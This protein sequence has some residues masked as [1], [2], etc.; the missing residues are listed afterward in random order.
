MERNNIEAVFSLSP[1][2]QGILF[3]ST[4][5]RAEDAYF[6]QISIDLRGCVDS[7]ALI[8]AWQCIIA[9]HPM[10]RTA[11]TSN[12]E[13]KPV[14]IVLKSAAMPWKELDWR[15]RS[16][17]EQKSAFEQFLK[18]DR[19]H[20]LDFAK[21][22]LMRL[23]LIRLSDDLS[24]LVW[25]EHH[26]ALDGWSVQLL[27]NEL[28]SLYSGF[29]RGVAPALSVARP[30]RDYVS[31][32]GKQNHDEAE[33]YWRD[34]LKGFQAVTPIGKS[35]PVGVRS[36]AESVE[37]K[38]AT[39]EGGLSSRIQA[40]GRKLRLTPNTIVQGAWAILLSRYSGED[41]LVY[42][43]TVS[44]RPAELQGVESTVG[45]FIN[46]L[47]VRVT[48]APEDSVID[49]LRRMQAQQVNTREYEYSSL[50]DVQK[51]SELDSRG[52]LFDSIFVFE[53]YPPLKRSEAGQEDITIAG[54]SAV[55]GSNYR[56][57]FVAG[58]GESLKLKMLYSRE[59]FGDEINHLIPHF[60]NV[61]ES[62]LRDPEQDVGRISL[63]AADENT[64]ILAT[65]A[66]PSPAF[67]LESLA[68]LFEEQALV[69][70]GRVAVESSEG[71]L[72]YSQLNEQADRLAGH[73]R[74]KGAGPEQVVG[75]SVDRS[76]RMIV[77]L[78]G[79]LK[80][81]AAYLSLDAN[82]PPA[83]LNY[84]IQDAQLRLV[85]TEQQYEDRFTSMVELVTVDDGRVETKTD[86]LSG[87]PAHSAPKAGNLAY[88]IYTSGS[89]GTPKGVG[90]EQRSVVRLVK[91]A[92]YLTFGP[93]ETFLQ[94]APLS[95][96]AS[97]LE[98][99]GCLLNGGRLVVF[100]PGLPSLDELASFI[101]QKG[102]TTVWLTAGLFSRMVEIH[103]ESL[104]GVRQL[105][106][107]GDVLSL[108]ATKKVL[109]ELPQV[110]LV[111]GYGPTEN[112][113]FTCCY[114]VT[115]EDDIVPS[116]PIGRPI[117]NTQAYILDR[118]LQLLPPGA[119]GELYAGGE[120][121]ARGYWNRPELTAEKFIPNP[122]SSV[123]GAR[124]YRTGDRARYRFDGNIEFLGRVDNQVK[125]R[126]FRIELEEI[127]AALARHP[128]VAEPTVVVRESESG[129]KQLVAFVVVAPESQVTAEDL[130]AFLETRLPGYMVPSL[131]VR[132][133]VLPLTENGKIDRKALVK[134]PLS[135]SIEDKGSGTGRTEVEK[136]LEA[137]W[138]A[139]LGTS[140]IQRMDNF[141]QLGGH[142]L[143]AMQVIS[144][145]REIF[146]IQVPLRAIFDFPVFKQM[147]GQIETLLRAQETPITKVQP[148]ARGE[149]LLLSYT[150]QQLWFLHQFEPGNLSFNMR[151][152]FRLQGQIDIPALQRSIT[153]LTVRHEALRT[154]F[155]DIDGEPVQVVHH[156]QQIDLTIVDLSH[157]EQ[158]EAQAFS[159]I[160]ETALRRYDLSTGPLFRPLI[161]RL[162]EAE[163]I[164][165]LAMHHIISDGQSVKVLL[166]DLSCLYEKECGRTHC[167]LPPQELQYA[168]YAAWQRSWLKDETLD[169]LL[170]YWK[171]Q[172][173]DCPAGLQIR[174]SY[175]RPDMRQ[176]LGNTYSW[177][178]S[179][180]LANDLG[181]L[182]RR[183]C[184]TEFMVLLTSFYVLL[185]FYSGQDDLVVGTDTANRNTPAIE[186]V[187]G[188]FTN[189]V[190]LRASLSGDP[191]FLE[192]LARVRKSALGAYIHQELPFE[193][194]VEA[195]RIE[196]HLNRAPIFQTKFIFQHGGPETLRLHAL[197]ATPM[198]VQSGRSSLDLVL[199]VLAMPEGLMA[200]F[201]YDTEL[202]NEALISRMSKVFGVVLEH[203]ATRP[204]LR[205]K[206]IENMMDELDNKEQQETAPKRQSA[207][208]SKLKSI[209]PKGVAL[210]RQELVRATTLPQ[211]GE[212]PLVLEPGTGDVDLGSWLEA[213][214]EFVSSRLLK[215]GAILFR[216]FAET[217]TSGFE[218]VAAAVCKD[219]YN[220][221]GE[222]PRESVSGNVYTP[223]FYPPDQKLLW[224]NENSFNHTW[225][226]K[227]LFCSVQPAQKGGET[228]IV[229]SRK[230]FDAIPAKVR[231]RFLEK[232]VMYVRNYGTGVGLDWQTVFRTSDRH[233][234]EARCRKSY[235]DFEWKS[236]GGLRTR[237]VRPAAICHESTGEWSWFN[238]AQHWHI[239]CLPAATRESIVTLFREEDYP[240]HCYYGDGS[241]IADEDMA[242]IFDT[243]SPFEI[244][245]PWQKGD[246]MLLDNVLVAHARN[247]FTGPRKL[248]VALGDLH[249]FSAVPVPALQ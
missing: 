240:R 155:P 158:P 230:V 40:A 15:D 120:G 154:T 199:A 101:V 82:D 200:T 218:R 64:R 8:Q 217:T 219:L 222:H 62:I 48:M 7:Q 1:L 19:E 227:I 172:L 212:L 191:T 149:K 133:T 142:S 100:P 95:F 214:Q 169:S 135:A 31:W 236:D 94:F 103:P 53:N 50:V 110:R 153:R 118:Q 186:R 85:V 44:G 113:T 10:L 174:G 27:L 170:G 211:G 161:I 32:L 245:F 12:R 26:L 14:Q 76:A 157:V 168:D 148:V 202:F 185:H 66:G 84:M 36:E 43:A 37:E 239:S 2:Q 181:K 63:L 187:V 79:I 233:E 140:S 180:E 223:V 243:Y 144:R 116:V 124:L 164:L 98:I 201:E 147:A 23:T 248:L 16:P 225:P 226:G 162:S 90:V 47:P 45:P 139:V 70:P 143:L 247:A 137:V 206:E 126:G 177:M 224:H 210:E 52:P 78:L 11:F 71:F 208:L 4:L 74:Q 77:G 194:L 109:T 105:I 207:G 106:A 242:V 114:Q 165:V 220:E 184:A 29:C 167:D 51:W 28:L 195:L 117:S 42:G 192:L 156:D 13:G 80:A 5:N 175:P 246:I 128:D 75:I 146:Q 151:P 123:P 60:V 141:F 196:R 193:K 39:I 111:N 102:I 87:D 178:I 205:L 35:Q 55:E 241:P 163:H 81:G 179:S 234:V 20:L 136:V 132:E 229:D 54:I 86:L 173:H 18:T 176:A 145:I 198:P 83:S 129:D 130:R 72:T 189:Q 235:L 237:A 30:Y 41:D 99:W 216:G 57:A 33:R 68:A 107:G 119:I 97:T 160:Q 150:Q 24:R 91:G 138:Q 232:G 58:I 183:E 166:E 38:T 108:A 17:S 49:V 121:L 122:F 73:L 3:H 182:G 204:D 67:P 209:K 171:Q 22:P 238:Q 131:I 56:L 92:N 197:K 89:T 65:S 69:H 25:T 134:R 61:V 152:V 228:P 159:V 231:E 6:G 21:A 104:R 9:R 188:F 93:D 46:T 249:S 34:L 59:R 125:I 88:M 112:T 244:A 96:D 190:A 213:N 203:I 221:N 115:S 215:H 127:E